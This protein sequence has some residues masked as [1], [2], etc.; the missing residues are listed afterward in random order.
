MLSNGGV[1]CGARTFIK[2]DEYANISIIFLFQIMM[3][4][5][6]CFADANDII[7]LNYALTLEHLE[8]AFYTQGMNNFTVGSFAS[9]GYNSSV[10]AYFTL[11]KNHEVVSIFL[12]YLAKLHIVSY[13]ACFLNTFLFRHT[14]QPSTTPSRTCSV[15]RFL[16]A[17]IILW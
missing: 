1:C 13:I 7:A 11:I 9:A 14:L 15:Y 5:S 17:Y 10:Y 4:H 2:R 3:S 8:A 12:H 6:L 16:H